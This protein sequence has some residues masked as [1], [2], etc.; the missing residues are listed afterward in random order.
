MLLN[1]LDAIMASTNDPKRSKRV[2]SDSDSDMDK[3]IRTWPK[4]VVV[5]H[6]EEGSRLK[7]NPFA[8]SKAIQGIAGTVDSVK[9]LH[10]G[11]ILIKCASKTQSDNL[12]NTTTLLSTPVEVT[13]HKTLNYSKGII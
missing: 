11:S 6:K 1:Q 3:E 8:L 12:L 2:L 4:F 9:K 13:P 10:N 7:I 5:Q